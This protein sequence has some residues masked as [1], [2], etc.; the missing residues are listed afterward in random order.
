MTDVKKQQRNAIIL[1][2]SVAIVWG[3]GFIFNEIAIKAQAT[4]SFICLVRFVIATAV[5]GIVFWTKI[6]IKKSDLLYGFLCGLALFIAFLLLTIGQESVTPS[7]SAFFASMTT[8][9]LPFASWIFFKQKPSM[10]VYLSLCIYLCGITILCFATGN[11]VGGFSKGLIFTI[12]S[13]VAFSMQ[14]ITVSVGLKKTNYQTLNFLQLAFA[15]VLFIIYFLC[16]DLKNQMAVTLNIPQF[17]LPALGLALLSTFYAYSVQTYAQKILPPY[18]VSII[19]S[20]E[21]VSAV[22]FS[23][24]LGYDILKWNMVVG[25]LLMVTAVI[26]AELAPRIKLKRH[27]RLVI[28]PK[29]VDK[30]NLIKHEKNEKTIVDEGKENIDGEKTAIDENTVNINNVTNAPNLDASNDSDQ[31]K[32]QINDEKQIDQNDKATSDNATNKSKED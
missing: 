15:S 19:L 5:Y 7:F 11:N 31:T 18:Q 26:L 22:I 30:I 13:T 2:V 16:F 14:Y 9:I 4:S 3:L 6:K 25:G 21:T 10:F 1:C 32:K 12:L 23:V 27:A 29:S 24:I 28:I 20:Q 8:V 17:I